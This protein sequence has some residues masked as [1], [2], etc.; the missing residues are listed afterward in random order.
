MLIN[1]GKIS[2]R[3]D[4]SPDYGPRNL[5]ICIHSYPQWEKENIY[6]IVSYQLE[7]GLKLRDDSFKSATMK[8]RN[9][10]K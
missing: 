10:S 9:D 2:Q 5:N 6:H 4:C 7:V 3:S 8:H 1:T